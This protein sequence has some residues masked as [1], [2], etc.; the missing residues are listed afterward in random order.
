MH[1]HARRVRVACTVRVRVRVRA[2]AVPLFGYVEWPP[3]HVISEEGDRGSEVCVITHGEVRIA[4]TTACCHLL[5]LATTCCYYYLLL[6]LA[7]AYCH[8]LPLA[9]ACCC[10]LLLEYYLPPHT[11]VRIFARGSRGGEVD[12]GFV[13]A[14]D[15]RPW[16]G[17]MSALSSRPRMATIACTGSVQVRYA[18]YGYAYYGYTYHGSTY[19]GPLTMALLTTY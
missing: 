6:L 19:R 1:V 4:L 7:A 10:L 2:Q 18:Y 16:V 9:A 13:R 8:L 5:L 11:K 3:G 12:L 14:S 17:E 15:A